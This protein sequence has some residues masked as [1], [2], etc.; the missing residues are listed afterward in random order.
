MQEFTPTMLDLSAGYTAEDFTTAD[1]PPK[2]VII[3]G[4][5]EAELIARAQQGPDQEAYAAI[6]QQHEPRV[7]YAVRWTPHQEDVVQDTYIRG[8]QGLEGFRNEG[9]GMSAWLARIA[10]NRALDLWRRDNRITIQ[11]TD[12]HD[13]QSV[14]QTMPDNDSSIDRTIAAVARQMDPEAVQRVLAT[15][16]N[17]V[18]LDAARLLQIIGIEGRRLKDYAEIAGVAHMTANTRAMRIRQKLGHGP[19]R[20]VVFEALETEGIL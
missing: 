15:I 13:P 8:W 18:G 19:T 11:L 7:S 5:P 4:L 14:L 2:E 17:E 3:Q 6:F 20:A 10:H 9:R 12:P 16:E 1:L